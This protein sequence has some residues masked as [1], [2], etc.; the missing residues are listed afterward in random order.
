MKINILY[1]EVADLYGDLA[2]VKYLKKCNED[3]EII[4]TNLN[5]VP[6]FSKEKPDLIYLGSTTES[7]QKVIIEKLLPYR[8]RLIELIN[9][10]TIFLVTGNALEIF[11]RKIIDEDTGEFISGLNIFDMIAKRK[12]MN[13]HN[14]L[15]LGKFFDEK[16]NEE[17]EIVGFKSQFSH[18]YLYKLK[19]EGVQGLFSTIRGFDFSGQEV[20][21]H[22]DIDKSCDYEGIRKNNFFG[23]YLLGPLLILNPLF[24]KYILRLMGSSNNLIYED[25]IMD[26][27]NTRLREYKEEK[28]GFTY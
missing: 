1:P 3:F 14:S 8:E 7:Y 20:S 22:K 10:N 6:F 12:M 2:N 23:T 19:N 24:T 5:D 26:V 18:E 4:E 27:Y 16:D 15:F 17:I 13:R 28:R 21:N 9:D 11:G 25:V